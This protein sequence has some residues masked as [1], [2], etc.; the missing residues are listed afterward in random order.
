M[1]RQREAEQHSR[2]VAAADSIPQV[3]VVQRIVA[4][5]SK[6]MGPVV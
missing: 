1:R 6:C 2:L 5:R 4:V 3:V